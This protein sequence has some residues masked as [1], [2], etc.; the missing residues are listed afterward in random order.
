MIVK[1]LV[2]GTVESY[3]KQRSTLWGKAQKR[4]YAWYIMIDSIF[5]LT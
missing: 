2:Y 5:K 1:F 4:D 3:S